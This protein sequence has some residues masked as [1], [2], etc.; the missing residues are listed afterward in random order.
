MPRTSPEERAASFYRAGSKSPPPPRIL[1]PRAKAVWREIVG[2][3]PIDW[4]DGGNF[5]YLAD[6]CEEQA[7]LEEIW[8]ELRKV[9]PGSPES[10]R[11]T[12]ELKTVRGNLAT[13][14]RHLRLTVQ[15][16]VQRAAT[17]AGEKQ[18]SASNDEIDWRRGDEEIKVA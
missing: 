3:K 7:R 10:S 17:K 4:F 11:L 5:G 9:V 16:A 1:S 18:A 6:H 2:A 13:S 12:G 14:A 15:E 8:V